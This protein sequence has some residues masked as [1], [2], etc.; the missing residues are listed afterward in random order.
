MRPDAWYSRY[1]QWRQGKWQQRII[2]PVFTAV[3][4]QLFVTFNGDGSRDVSLQGRVSSTIVAALVGIV[5]W[6]AGATIMQNRNLSTVLRILGILLWGSGI[7]AAG[8]LIVVFN[9]A[10]QWAGF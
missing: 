1:R 6:T 7:V 4:F 3:V 9:Y 5:L 8:I 2:P 10:F